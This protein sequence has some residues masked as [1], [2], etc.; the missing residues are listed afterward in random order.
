MRRTAGPASKYLKGQLVWY[1]RPGQPLSEQRCARVTVVDFSATPPSY[2]VRFM[3]DP[4]AA[5][6]ATEENRLY[7]YDG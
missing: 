7:E 4:D 3:D 5:E 1:R 6:R 2:M